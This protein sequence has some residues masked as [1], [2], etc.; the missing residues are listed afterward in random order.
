MLQSI[1]VANG[2]LAKQFLEFPTVV[3]R[4]LH[5]GHEVIWDID[6]QSPSLQPDVEEMA[7]VLFP[8]QAGLAVLANTGTPAQAERAQSCRPKSRGLALEPLLD[9]RRGFFWSTHEVRITHGIRTVKAFRSII[10]SA[11]IYEF[12]DRN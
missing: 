7:G 2:S 3:E 12:R 5:I 1:G 4:P 9:I 11:M 8:F 6:G 10:V